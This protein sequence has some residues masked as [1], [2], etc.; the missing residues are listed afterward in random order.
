MRDAAPTGVERVKPSRWPPMLPEVGAEL[1]VGP[2]RHVL[3]DGILGA[4]SGG[5][6]R[7]WS[8]AEAERYWR[9]APGASHPARA[10]IRCIAE[11]T[12]PF[13]D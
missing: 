11:S 8:S 13:E 1:W 7:K 5:V 3:R 6:L 4:P 12:M 2:A 10:E 9:L